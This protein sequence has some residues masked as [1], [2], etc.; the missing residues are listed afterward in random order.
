MDD[1]ES[2]LPTN[3]APTTN[4]AA[5]MKNQKGRPMLAGDGAT[6]TNQHNFTHAFS[7]MLA[8]LA[9]A[10]RGWQVFP[11]HSIRTAD[12]GSRSCSCGKSGCENS[13]KHPRAAHGLKDATVDENQIRAWWD[14]WPD[15]NV[16]I[17]TGKESGMFVLDI[18]PKHDGENTLAQLVSEHGPLPETVEAKSGGGGRH[19]YFQHPGSAIKTRANCEPGIDI[20][21]DGGY[22]VA[23]PS[24]HM[25]G[26]TYQWAES[27]APEDVALAAAPRWVLEL[28]R[29]KPSKPA[30]GGT[31]AKAKRGEMSQAVAV[32]PEGSRHQRFTSLAGSM[33]RSGSSVEAVKAALNAENSRCVDGE[34][35]PHPLP[36]AEISA[37]LQAAEGWEE[38]ENDRLAQKDLVVRLAIDRYRFGRTKTGE[39]FAVSKSGPMIARTLRGSADALRGELARC[40]YETHR[41]VPS[42]ASLA[43]ALK[44]LEGMASDAAP[45]ETYIRVGPHEGGIVLDLGDSTGRAVVIT[46]VGWTVVPQSPILF[47]RTELIGLMP[48]PTHKPGIDGIQALRSLL[49]VSDES[50]PSVLAFIVA[51]FLPMIEHPVL[52]LGGEQSTGKSTAAEIIGGLIDPSPCPLTTPPRDV[53]SWAIVA[54]AGWVRTLDNV[55]RIPEWLSDAL[56]R[57]VTGDALL[58]RTLFT[59]GGVSI[60]EFRRV[61]IITSIDVDVLRG[62]LGSRCLVVELEPIAKRLPKSELSSQYEELRLAIVA[63]LLDLVVGVLRLWNSIHIDDG[64]RLLDFAKVCI[65]LDEILGIE[66]FDAYCAQ[67]GHIAEDVVEGDSVALAIAN[68][69]ERCPSGWTGTATQLLEAIKPPGQV[70]KDWPTSGKM[71]SGRIK[72][73]TPALKAIGIEVDRFKDKGPRRSRQIR[74]FKAVASSTVQ[75]VH[76]SGIGPKDGGKAD[77]GRTVTPERAIVDLANRPPQTSTHG[78]GA[79]VRGRSDDLDD[80][81]PRSS[82]DVFSS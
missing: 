72:R 5:G 76:P 52:M 16:G 30:P 39:V 33:R 7:P 43:D 26:G 21:A 49:N 11:V 34:G 73:A 19:F 62:D 40:F 22:I 75:S 53:D 58:R 79:G 69:V 25:S 29:R 50:W 12:D 74:L 38:G 23:D 24:N 3:I 28:S 67:V 48:E 57:V 42:S 54:A 66:A 31:A 61:V 36:E 82:F 45:E 6:E 51:A 14:K 10:R 17:R 70:P 78:L 81:E 4:L 27:R 9:Y 32:I 20:R 65:A 13:G 63:A 41:K 15:A 56:C 77:Q 71:L 59:D 37:I 2:A 44:V 64:P 46:A 1:R 18:D 68:L 80:P 55:S 47:R 60:V 35:N 8:A